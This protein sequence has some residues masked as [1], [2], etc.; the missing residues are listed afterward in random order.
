MSPKYKPIRVNHA[1][2]LQANI[3][4]LHPNLL[5]PFLG[6]AAIAFLC[7]RLFQMRVVHA[8]VVFSWL[9]SSWWIVTGGDNWR[10][11]RRFNAWVQRRWVHGSL[12]YQ[13]FLSH[14]TNRKKKHQRRL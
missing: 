5:L 11:L 10:F 14:D 2:G 6:S 8:G 13:S 1:V 9:F 4:P 12:P 3:G 7:Y